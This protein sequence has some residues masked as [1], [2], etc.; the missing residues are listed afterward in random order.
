MDV[1]AALDG[2][3]AAFLAALLIASALHKAVDRRRMSAS[4]AALVGGGGGP[5]HGLAMLGLA[6]GVE[7]ACGLALLAPPTRPLGAVA[8]ATLWSLYLLLILRALAAGRRGLDCGCA[9]GR[10]TA[11]LGYAEVVRNLTLILL[12]LMVAGFAGPYAVGVLEILAGLGLLVLYVAVEQ[13]TAGAI[14]R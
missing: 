13:V 9:F 5:A 7:L 4:V 8:A 1:I 14:P 12:G 6:G 10:K 11:P 3:I 2:Y